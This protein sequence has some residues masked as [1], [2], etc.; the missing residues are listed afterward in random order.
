MTNDDNVNKDVIVVRFNEE[1]I[2]L[3]EASAESILLAG[4]TL[5]STLEPKE[6]SRYVIWVT[7]LLAGSVV[8]DSG[9]VLPNK[10]VSEGTDWCELASRVPV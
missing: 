9:L 4:S 1:V 5:R 8:E 7:A 2:S 10:M 6:G 3:A